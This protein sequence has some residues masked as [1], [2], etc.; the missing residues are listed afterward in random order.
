MIVVAVR[1]DDEVWDLAIWIDGGTKEVG[2]VIVVIKA[3]LV[4]AWQ[5]WLRPDDSGE[6]RTRV[7]IRATASIREDNQSRTSRS[8]GQ[9]DCL[10]IDVWELGESVGLPDKVGG[11]VELANGEREPFQP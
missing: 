6:I 9:E 8:L 11:W 4:R 5:D 3:R 7:E 1:G 2:K 10:C